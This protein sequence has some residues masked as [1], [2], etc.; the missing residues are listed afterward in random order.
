MR[1]LVRIV[2]VLTA[3]VAAPGGASA[4]ISDRDVAE[5]VG[6]TVRDYSQF[7]I[8]DDVN[9]SVG[10][11]TVT[12]SGCVTMPFKR[13]EIGGRVAKIEGV[14]KLINDLHVLPVSL[15]DS[16]LR[17]RVA[18]AIYGHPAFWPYATMARPPIHIIVEAGHVTLTGAVNSNVERSLAFALAQV[19]GAFGVKNGLRVDR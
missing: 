15:T 4:Q 11:G 9:I 6:A 2:C 17:V 3:L 1:T 10:A 19:P 7:S 18:Q 5:K 13:D 12:L 8:F 14:R 16:D